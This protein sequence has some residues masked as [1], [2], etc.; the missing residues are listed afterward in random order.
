M[1]RSGFSSAPL[2][3]PNEPIRPSAVRTCAGADCRS[4]LVRLSPFYGFLFHIR[5]KNTCFM[6]SQSI[7]LFA[8]PYAWT[9]TPSPAA[10]CFAGRKQKKNCIRSS[11]AFSFKAERAAGIK[12]PRRPFRGPWTQT[13]C[14]IVDKTKDG[15][16]FDMTGRA[17]VRLQPSGCVAAPPV[18]RQGRLD[19]R[20]AQVGRS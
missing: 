2:C 14:R 12:A 11:F 10:V 20:R 9:A 16:S 13:F 18:A 15:R 17:S 5:R 8:T 6:D 7:L 4:I 3:L 1:K 19:I